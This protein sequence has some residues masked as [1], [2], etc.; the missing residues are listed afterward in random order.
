M[1]SLLE[2]HIEE[3]RNR[4]T[5]LRDDLRLLESKIDT[6]NDFKVKTIFSAKLTSML[7]SAACG[8]VT[9]AGTMIIEYFLKKN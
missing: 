1:D 3:T 8:L 2:H 4:F 9:F 7:I 6:L 5:E